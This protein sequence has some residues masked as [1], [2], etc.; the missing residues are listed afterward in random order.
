[1]KNNKKQID[2]QSVGMGIAG[3]ILSLISFFG[4]IVPYFS[5]FLAVLG[6]I[7]SGLQMKKFK[8]GLSVAGLVLGILGFLINLFWLFVV[9]VLF[10]MGGI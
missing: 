3:F 8:T 5:I 9:G 2:D 6:I 1:M 10:T 4:W 7:F